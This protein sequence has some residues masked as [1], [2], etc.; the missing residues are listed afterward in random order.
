MLAVTRRRMNSVDFWWYKLILLTIVHNKI[1]VRSFATFDNKHKNNKQ[2]NNFRRSLENIVSIS[3]TCHNVVLSNDDDG[4]VKDGNTALNFTS[5]V[6][7]TDYESPK[8]N[9]TD[10]QKQQ[11][12]SKQ[13]GL[14]L[15]SAILRISYDGARFS[16]WSAANKNNDISLSSQRREKKYRIR[17]TAREFQQ[18]QLPTGFV[19]S[20][21]GVLKNNLAKLYGD[22][23]PNT[24]IIVEGSS[25]TDKGVHALYM[26]A[27]IYC[28]KTEFAISS[29]SPSKV[30]SD[31]Y[32][33][34]NNK[35]DNNNDDAN[36]SND[37]ANNG[38]IIS[39]K[40]IPH[41]ATPS[42][43]SC[44]EVLPM[45]ANLSKIAYTLNRMTPEDIQVI[46]IAPTP[47]NEKNNAFH[48]SLSSKSKTY[49]YRLS[50]GYTYDPILRKV[51][52]HVGS[53]DLDMVKMKKACEL[54][55]GTHAFSA[56][57]GA[58]RGSDEKQKRMKQR[59]GSFS[60]STTICTLYCIRV[61][62][63]H[64]TIAHNEEY[65]FPGVDPP[66]RNYNIVVKGDRFLYK[67][68]RFIVGSFVALG[69]GKLELEDI[70]RAINTGSWDIL[71]DPNDRR[72]EFKCAPAYGLSLTHVDYGDEVSLEWQPLRD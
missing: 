47:S 3:P 46:G 35:N 50:T 22:V 69:N 39:G 62:V 51:I 55:R 28:L 37:D 25:R 29:L 41:P 30:L 36:N 59:E 32:Y 11:Q 20:V 13:T 38:V 54:F 40:R 53:S 16:G 26:I 27:Q 43:D 48:A 44:F 61:D 64:P 72:K 10:Q 34:R 1:T 63:Q 5:D 57:Q 70:Q 2:H 67:M 49:E 17:G 9:E 21:E 24:R 7:A 66:I 12:S 15:T 52:W 4:F 56:F 19:R 6:V 58:P 71:N 8:D 45:N 18:Q 60:S 14:P 68:V 65:Y 42:D 33:G 23:D 31:N